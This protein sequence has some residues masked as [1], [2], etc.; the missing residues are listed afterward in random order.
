MRVTLAQLVKF[1]PKLK[2]L[3][4]ILDPAGEASKGAREYVQKFYPNLKK[5]NPNLAILVRE[6]NGVQ[7]RL[8]ARYAKGKEISISL[9]NQAA[10]DI[11]KQIE[12]VGK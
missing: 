6:C 2:E 5:D 8:Y 7:P 1:T 4:I 9:T 12:A 11:H 10:P 3:R